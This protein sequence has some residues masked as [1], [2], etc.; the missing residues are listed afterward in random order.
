[1]IDVKEL[2]VGNKV[3]ANGLHGGAIRT[4]E[5]ISSSGTLSND[6]RVI[7]FKEHATGEFIK[8]CDGIPMDPKILEACGFVN[9]GGWYGLFFDTT[10]YDDDVTIIF[11]YMDGEINI[12]ANDQ[13]IKRIE[14]PSVHI[15]QNTYYSLTGSELQVNLKE[16]MSES[17]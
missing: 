17:F 4:V 9:R 13:R 8:D 7:L 2:R 14:T 12:I 15:I 5:Q 1:M 10:I 11:E 6:N 16:S 3:I